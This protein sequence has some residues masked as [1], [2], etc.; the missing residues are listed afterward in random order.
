M[1][2][3]NNDKKRVDGRFYLKAVLPSFRRKALNKDKENHSNFKAKTYGFFL[4]HVMV[5]SLEIISKL[6]RKI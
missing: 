3:K 4:N 1:V 2:K 6:L 5:H